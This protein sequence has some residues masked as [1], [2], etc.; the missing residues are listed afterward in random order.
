MSN[1]HLFSDPYKIGKKTLAFLM[2]LPG[3]VMRQDESPV[4]PAD[5]QLSLPGLEDVD[6]TCG[7]VL[8]VLHEWAQCWERLDWEQTRSQRCEC[9]AACLSALPWGAGNPSGLGVPTKA[10]R[11][12]TS[13][14]LSP[15]S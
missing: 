3:L 5:F 7:Q 9:S 8:T 6:G 11:L 14:S 1:S 4:L 2:P 12:L 13:V 10:E 15:V